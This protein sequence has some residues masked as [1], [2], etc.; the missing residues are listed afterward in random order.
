MPFDI[1]RTLTKTGYSFY[2]PSILPRLCDW[3]NKFFRRHGSQT[4]LPD[5]QNRLTSSLPA[6]LAEEKRIR[7]ASE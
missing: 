5:V 3:R 1:P 7:K 2:I 6:V 4:F